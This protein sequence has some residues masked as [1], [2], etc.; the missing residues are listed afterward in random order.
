MDLRILK[1]AVFTPTSKGWGLPLLFWG[2]SGVGKSDVIE[3]FGRRWRLPVVVLA[4]GEMGE[5]AFGV[6]PVPKDIGN[7]VMRMTYPAPDWLDMFED[8][9]GRGIVF[10][11][12]LTTAEPHIQAAELGLINS[13][14]I[15]GHY[16]GSGVRVLAA[17]NDPRKAANGHELTPP[18]A[19]RLGHIDWSPPNEEEWGGYL[20]GTNGLAAPTK[21]E[22]DPA[23]EEKRVTEA[24]PVAWARASGLIATF[25]NRNRGN[26]YRQFESGHPLSGR[27][28]PSHRSWTKA[29][30]ALASADV[31]G[32]SEE[33]SA[34]LVSGFVGAGGV[35]SLLAFRAAM[36]LPDPADLL[37]GR[38]NWNHDPNRLD[39]SM[40]VL[41]TLASYVLSQKISDPA[42]SPLV[43]KLWEFFDEVP[44]DDLVTMAAVPV[45]KA[46][47]STHA[48]A[49]KVLARLRPMLQAAGLL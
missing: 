28:W 41:S 40:A 29:T 8:F 49:I 23:A 33:E 46:R 3:D 26:L 32:L 30:A 45:V 1:A 13:R 22:N 36:D 6:T 14:R 7:G 34:L 42:K 10:C 11:D 43:G 39:R 21:S 18:L 35:K 9:D 24:W 16:L 47:L 48:R 2:D 31:H 19:N 37:S 44:G 4:P 12:E 38:T 27:A 17:A 25:H 5:G 15:G 20:V